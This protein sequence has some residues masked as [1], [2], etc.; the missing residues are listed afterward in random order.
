MQ[1]QN[2]MVESKVF[3]MIF[4]PAIDL[5]ALWRQPHESAVSFHKSLSQEG[6]ATCLV[7]WQ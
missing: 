6:W 1:Q 2:W 5:R 4:L 3:S 7:T